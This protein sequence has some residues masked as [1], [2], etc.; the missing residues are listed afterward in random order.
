[1]KRLTS[2]RKAD[3]VDE[4]ASNVR[5]IRSAQETHLSARLLVKKIDEVLETNRRFTPNV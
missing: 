4:D 2:T 5:G 3:D 1:M